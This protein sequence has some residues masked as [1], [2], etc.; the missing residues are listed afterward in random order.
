MTILREDFLWG[1]STAA[2][3]A[4]QK[5]EARLLPSI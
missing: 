1:A 2:F 5:S 3:S 4:A